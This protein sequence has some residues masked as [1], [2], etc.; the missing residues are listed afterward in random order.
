MEILEILIYDGVVYCDL[1]ANMSLQQNEHLF[2][3]KV[4]EKKIC[5]NRKLYITCAL[6]FV[7]CN[8]FLSFFNDAVI[9]SGI[10]APKLY[11]NYQLD[12]LIIIYS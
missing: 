8:L 1:T 11:I 10:M 2:Q 9:L 7:H 12:A 6:F 4:F 3:Q 5:I